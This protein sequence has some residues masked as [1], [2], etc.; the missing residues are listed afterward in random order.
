MRSIKHPGVREPQVTTLKENATGILLLKLR[1]GVPEEG[2]PPNRLIEITFER[3]TGPDPH[4]KREQI[5]AAA[6]GWEDSVA[7]VKHGDQELQAASRRARA[8]LPQLQQEFAKGFAPGELLQVK[9]PFDTPDGGHEY[10]WVEVA[11]WKGDKITGLLNNEP[12][13][14]PTLHAGQEVT[15]SAT[16]I[17]DYIRRR[18]D[19][20]SEGNEPS[21]VSERQGK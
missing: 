9:I 21:K 2:D 15:V 10:M 4:A 12:R 20:T 5:L 17:F 11:T 19:G 1:E 18:P 6:F 7:Q 3:G 14:I 8:Q 16:K 13:S